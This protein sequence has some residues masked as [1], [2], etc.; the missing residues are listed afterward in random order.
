M[1]VMGWIFL[2]VSWSSLSFFT[3]WCLVKILQPSTTHLIDADEEPHT[4]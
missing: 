4:M 1:T 2:I 3:G